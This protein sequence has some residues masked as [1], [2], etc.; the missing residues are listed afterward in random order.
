MTG[1]HVLEAL[2]AAMR[3]GDV[4]S[5]AALIHADVTVN[6]PASLPYGGSTVAS[7]RSST[8]SSGASSAIDVYPNDTT[9]LREVLES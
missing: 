7:R 4:E 6:E 3:A 1:V 2:I 8:T 9:A 5:A